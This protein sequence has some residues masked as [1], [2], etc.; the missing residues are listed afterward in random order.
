MLG[1]KLFNDLPSDV[2]Q[3]D[4]SLTTFKRKL[5]KFLDNVYD[6][7]PLPGYIDAANGNTK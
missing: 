3:F 4:G 2:R 1:P 5:D 7:P 6:K